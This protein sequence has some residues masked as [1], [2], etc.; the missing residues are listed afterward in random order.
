MNNI[1]R[2]TIFSHFNFSILSPADIKCTLT[3]TNDGECV[4]CWSQIGLKV[5]HYIAHMIVVGKSMKN[6]YYCCVIHFKKHSQTH[7]KTT[8][9]LY[10]YTDSVDSTFTEAKHTSYHIFMKQ[11]MQPFLT[12]SW[13]ISKCLYLVFP[14]LSLLL[15]YTFK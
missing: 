2:T 12:I 1:S 6:D 15:L 11:Q 5:Q 3:V 7:F 10:I 13:L 4:K 8:Y 9:S 14:K